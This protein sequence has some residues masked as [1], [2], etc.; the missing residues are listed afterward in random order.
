MSHRAFE[1]FTHACARVE[2]VLAIASMKAEETSRFSA[3]AQASFAV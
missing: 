3:V 1:A 2:T